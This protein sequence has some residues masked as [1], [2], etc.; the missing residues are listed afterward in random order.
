MTDDPKRKLDPEAAG[1]RAVEL[2][3]KEKWNCAEAICLAVGEQT[4][5]AIPVQLATAFG[6]GMGDL[7]GACGCVSGALLAMGPVLGRSR[8]DVRKEAAAARKASEF[9]G[10]FAERFRGERC[11][12]INHG[13]TDDAKLRRLCSKYVRFAAEEA[14]R[15]HQVAGGGATDSG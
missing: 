8:P 12:E 11:G 2:F 7:Q 10:R 14:V 9:R 6:A 5:R 15:A 13:V 1:E 3:V 4:G